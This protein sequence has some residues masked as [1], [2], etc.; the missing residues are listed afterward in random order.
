MK[1]SPFILY[2]E[3]FQRFAQQ[4]LVDSPYICYSGSCF[5]Q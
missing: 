5:N 2:G 1:T 3:L 4:V